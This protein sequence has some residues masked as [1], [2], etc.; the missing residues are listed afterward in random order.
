[1]KR[2]TV[3]LTTMLIIAFAFSSCAIVDE[4]QQMIRRIV[5]VQHRSVADIIPLANSIG[6]ANVKYIGDP[7]GKRIIIQAPDEALINEARKLIGELDVPLEQKKA[8][9]DELEIQTRY[10]SLKN[11]DVKSVAGAIHALSG[12]IAVVAAKTRMR[13]HAQRSLPNLKMVEDKRN[14]QIIISA[15]LTDA[16]WGKVEEI[17]SHMDIPNQDVLLNLKL[18][19]ASEETEEGTKIPKELKPVSAQL[20]K[21]FD[22]QSYQVANDVNFRGTVSQEFSSGQPYLK[23]RGSITKIDGEVIGLDIDIEKTFAEKYTI[24]TGSRQ[25]SQNMYFKFYDTI[26]IKSGETLII[27][28]SKLPEINKHVLLVLTAKTVDPYK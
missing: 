1:M 24:V 25:K 12:E 17:I 3:T 11:A 13:P 26:Q 15:L 18:V 28:G 4:Q 27:G 6:I 10:F 20:K 7:N 19:L 16:E 2:L 9:P 21:M 8:E 22:Y 5:P 23:I 14:R